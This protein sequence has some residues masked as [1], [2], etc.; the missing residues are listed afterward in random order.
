MCGRYASF[1]S[2][3]DLADAFDVQH[4]SAAAAAVAAAYN[5]A[6]TDGVRI[7]VERVP[8][9]AGAAGVGRITGA[10]TAGAGQ[11]AGEQTTGEQSA[12]RPHREMHVARWGL[13]PPWAKD[14]RV[15]ARMINARSES[16][17]TKSSFAKPLATKRCIVLADGYYEWRKDDRPGG[18]KPVKTPFYIHSSDGA[19]IAF[20]GLYSWWPDPSKDSDDPERWLLS[21]TI[22]TQE[23][24]DGLEQIHDREPAVLNHALLPAWLDPGSTDTAE[25]LD[26]LAEPAP[27]LS[28]HEVGPAVGSVRNIGPH[29]IEPV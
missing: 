22:I 4:I 19:P 7:V 3:Q 20:A 10:R 14:Q 18:G 11:V 28:W 6:P 21:T 8:K 1:R 12:P 17:A 29:L 24:R 15:G 26:V 23:A 2:A 5:V 25:A 9:G 27:P 13:V 16:L